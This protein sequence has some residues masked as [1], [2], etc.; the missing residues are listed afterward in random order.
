MHHFADKVLWRSISWRDKVKYEIQTYKNT[1]NQTIFKV[2][3]IPPSIAQLK[4]TKGI[5]ETARVFKRELHN[6]STFLAAIRKEI[7]KRVSTK[8]SIQEIVRKARTIH[9]TPCQADNI[10]RQKT[11]HLFFLNTTHRFTTPRKNF[12]FPR[13]IAN[14]TG[15]SM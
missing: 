1:Y 5:E 12:K 6:N 8:R 4:L 10:P 15:H 11:P 2:K 3:T 7:T 13:D 9:S 14:V